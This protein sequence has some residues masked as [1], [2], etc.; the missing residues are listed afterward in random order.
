MKMIET[1]KKWGLVLA[2]GGGKGAYQVGVMR[3]IRE[4]LPGIDIAAIS[5]SSVGSLNMVLFQQEDQILS[6][7]IWSNITPGQFLHTELHMFDFKDGIMTRDGLL[8][9]IDNKI[10]LDKITHS[11]R[12][13]YATVS[14]YTSEDS[15]IAKAEYLKLNGCSKD[16]IKDIL[17]A[18]SAIPYIYE[19]V[20]IDGVKY[21]DGGLADNLPIEPLYDM[22]IRNMIVIALSPDTILNEHRFPGTEFLYIK[23]GRS[24][25]DIFGG[26]LDFSGYN[27]AVRMKMGYLDGIREIEF[28]G[29]DENDAEFQIIKQERQRLEYE[30]FSLESK[31]SNIQND[32]NRNMDN[33][34]KYLKSYVP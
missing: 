23:P 22:G 1:D 20:V 26:T 11:H 33:L 16:K 14:K 25:G 8:S 27:A 34:L 29:R 4:K 18:S 15:M 32:I 31:V 13:L 19:S 30:Q 9:I 21:R 17:L 10:D 7:E 2:G 5:G 28:Y 24:L 12:A 6:E 3:A